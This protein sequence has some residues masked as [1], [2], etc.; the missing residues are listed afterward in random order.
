M[1]HIGHVTKTKQ[2]LQMSECDNAGPDNRRYSVM[3]IVT[4]AGRLCHLG[5]EHFPSLLNG[6]KAPR[7]S[8]GPC[9]PVLKCMTELSVTL[10]ST[11]SACCREET[12]F[13]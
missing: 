13:E 5:I 7:L 2:N 8:Q 11:A 6:Q 9:L 3:Q 1:A 4:V 12:S 10:Q